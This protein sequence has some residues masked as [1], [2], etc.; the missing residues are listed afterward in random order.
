MVT[1]SG[2]SE[3]TA[4]PSKREL[5]KDLNS[6]EE[7]LLSWRL[8]GEETLGT[9][10]SEGVSLSPD[11][12]ETECTLPLFGSLAV[13]GVELMRGMVFNVCGDSCH[14]NWFASRNTARSRGCPNTQF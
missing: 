4:E 14:G 7:V 2:D 12:L 11:A 8:A 9:G 6:E 1:R 10:V 13:T 3:A 5:P